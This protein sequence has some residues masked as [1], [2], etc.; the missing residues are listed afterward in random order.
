MLLNAHIKMIVIKTK[1]HKHEKNRLP[2]Q[3]K[4]LGDWKVVV[5]ISI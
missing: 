5:H 4:R 2:P 1:T 3:K